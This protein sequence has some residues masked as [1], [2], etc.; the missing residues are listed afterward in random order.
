MI[1]KHLLSRSSTIRGAYTISVRT[2]IH[3]T[4]A[5]V[6]IIF[7]Q[8]FTI[9]KR[10]FKYYFFTC[11]TKFKVEFIHGKSAI[12]K[13]SAYAPLRTEIEKGKSYAWCSCGS[14]AKQPFCDGAH[15][16]LN[17][18]LKPEETKFAPLRFTC[19]E[20][21]T[22]FFCTCKGSSNRP[23]CDGTHSLLKTKKDAEAQF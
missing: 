7:Q 12:G 17:A 13:P 5:A 15:K 10:R 14:S 11:C 22:V 20:S 2:K 18:A 6:T 19:E 16:K 9:Y 23:F 8:K 21:R 3:P 4:P 1:G